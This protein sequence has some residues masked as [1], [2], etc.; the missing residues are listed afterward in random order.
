MFISQKILQGRGGINFK[1]ILRIGS[2]TL[3]QVMDNLEK[4]IRLMFLFFLRKPFI[5]SRDTGVTRMNTTFL[6][7]R[8]GLTLKRPSYRPTGT[9]PS[10]RFVLV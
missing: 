2:M 10:P 5:T 1:N 4:P 8:L 7:G 6:E 3:V 9:H